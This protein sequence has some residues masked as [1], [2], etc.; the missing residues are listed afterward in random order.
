MADFI[1]GKVQFG[2]FEAD[3]HTQELRKN[4]VKLKLGG[5]PF[6]ILAALL[7]KHGELVTREELRSRIWPADTFVDFNH[8]LNA[9]VNKLR[10]TLSDSVEQPRYVET[11][12]R[13]GYR[14]IATV[15]V[16][17]VA[18]PHPVTPAQGSAP[19]IDAGSWTIPTGSGGRRY[20]WALT[21]ALILVLFLTLRSM[22][23]HYGAGLT[24]KLEQERKASQEHQI[25]AARYITQPPGIWHLNL[26]YPQD[27]KPSMVIASAKDRNE[28]TQ[29]SPDGK[30]LAFMSDR[31]GSLEIWTM[32]RD[33]SSP[34]KLT[35]VGNCGSPRW[36]PDSRWIAFDAVADGPPAVFVVA[37]AGGPARK[38]VADEWENMVPSWSND[39]KWIYFASHRTGDDQVWRVPFDG[40]P[41]VQVTQQGGFAT[42]ESFDGQTLYYAKTRFENPEI[43]KVPSG[44]GAERR[45]SPLLHPRTWANWALTEK[46]ILFLNDEN[47]PSATLE[48]YDFATSG[49]RPVSEIEKPSFWLSASKD[50]NSVWYS[51]KEEEANR[52]A[53]RLELH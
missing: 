19:K 21:G 49:V 6:A 27:P 22:T 24:G 11:L 41:A 47:D 48:F 25:L 33:G 32:N 26:A 10:E 46:G 31:S 7:E 52:A 1:N 20:L 9:A 39:S 8:G 50:A 16:P 18:V 44:G 35:D 51:W 40:G 42:A 14:F 23:D 3:F 15:E 45:V 34:Q 2:P 4:G 30:K 36:S 5:Q 53:L 29:P 37:A 38:V 12:P 17:A 13:R 43:W 28:G